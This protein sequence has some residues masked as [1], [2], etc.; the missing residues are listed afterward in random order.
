MKYNFEEYEIDIKELFRIL[1]RYTIFIFTLV[2]I[3]TSISIVYVLSKPNIYVVSATIAKQK[4]PSVILSKDNYVFEYDINEIL[5]SFDFD[6]SNL[7]RD[8][9]FIKNFIIKNGFDKEIISGNLEKNYVFTSKGRIIYEFLKN[10]K[11]EENK[12]NK[13]VNFFA[14]VYMPFISGFSIN[15]N[16]KTEIVSIK[17]TH[18]NRFF[19]Y[20]VV[21]AFLRDGI[22]YLVN[23]NLKNLD[24]QIKKYQKA[25]KN[26]DNLE[27]KSELA[28]LIFN[29]LKQKTYI[30]TSEVYKI[31]Q[32][33][34]IP[35]ETNKAGPKR[36][37]F[38]AVSFVGSLVVA[39]V[40]VFAI[41]FIK[42]L[43]D[44]K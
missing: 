43:K 12:A 31:K 10:S 30:K 36:A 29:L 5:K 4:M 37:T 32:E 20:K 27:V 23:K 18:P 2:F 25:I 26:T 8:Y 16:K 19:A 44:G 11:N 42:H 39:I 33:P 14:H 7:I 40:L 34:Y 13:K 21:K 28:N 17:Y 24:Y 15:K 35:N 6:Y 3:V 22:K 1:G 9:F 38:V 41:E